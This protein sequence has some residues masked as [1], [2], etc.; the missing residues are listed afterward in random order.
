MKK[1]LLT[2]AMVALLA[3]AASA[4]PKIGMWLEETMENCDFMA[5]APFSQFSVWVWVEPSVNGAFCAEY[6]MVAPANV[7]VQ[8]AVENPD[9]AL[10]MGAAVGAPGISICFPTCQTGWFW[11]YQVPCYATDA[12]TPG[13]FTI[14]FHDDTGDYNTATCIEPDRPLE[15]LVPLNQFGVNAP[16]VVGTE[17]SSW[18][19]IK[20]MF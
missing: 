12:T 18:G 5:P 13:Y 10:S 4:Q 9:A 8:S 17:E 16:C 14:E 20:S 3:G 2:V 15:S 6:K 19:A 11:T 7:I 1:V